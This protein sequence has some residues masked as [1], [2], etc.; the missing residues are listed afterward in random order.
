MGK[1]NI[2]YQYVL[3]FVVSDVLGM[4]YCTQGVPFA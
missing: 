1:W 3:A 2:V 4:Y